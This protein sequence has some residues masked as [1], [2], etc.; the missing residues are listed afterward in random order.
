MTDEDLSNTLYDA[1]AHVRPSRG[2]AE[3]EARLDDQQGPRRRLAGSVAAVAA[4]VL[5]TGG[6][7]WANHH[8][9]EPRPAPAAGASDLVVQAY[10]LGATANGPRLFLERH[11]LQD[12]TA[13]PVQAAVNAALGTPDDPDYHSGF[14]RGTTA[15]VTELGEIVTVDF[16]D[17]KLAESDVSDNAAAEAMQA[18][19][20]TVNAAEQRQVQVQF[21]IDGKPPTT[22]LGKV[23]NGPMSE[24]SADTVLSPVS[25]EVAEGAQLTR[26]SLITGHAAAFEANVVWELRQG[27]QIVK[28]GYATAGECC[29]LSP[30]AFN[31]DAP[32]GSYTLV[33]HDVDESG[34]EGNGTTSDSKDIVIQ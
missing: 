1:V 16:R 20:W 13:S 9:Q 23:L 14:P 3:I 12:V 21:T 25:L 28:Q 34:G 11:Q 8:A 5:V 18:L 6:V 7:A 27:Q 17:P 26:G 19:V 24:Q 22:L 10:F 33:V 15:R 4:I 29:T 2:I 30:F 31:L 32:P